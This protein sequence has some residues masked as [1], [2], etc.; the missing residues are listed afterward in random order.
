[1]EEKIISVQIE[2][3]QKQY[4]ELSIEQYNALAN[5][6]QVSIFCMISNTGYRYRLYNGRINIS[7]LI[8]PKKKKN[9]I[10]VLDP[11]R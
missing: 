11:N 1:M 2:D 9:R 3:P 4:L 7:W 6:K 10:S 5:K 8:D